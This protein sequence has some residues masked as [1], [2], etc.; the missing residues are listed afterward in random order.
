MG[1]HIIIVVNCQAM[2][3]APVAA[4]IPRVGESMNFLKTMLVIC[5]LVNSS[6]AKSRN[7]EV[8]LE[9]KY[10]QRDRSVANNWSPNVLELEN[11]KWIAVDCTAVRNDVTSQSPSMALE[12]S[13]VELN[14]ESLSIAGKKSRKAV[15]FYD[16]N[17]AI[18]MEKS[19]YKLILDQDSGR[20]ISVIQVNR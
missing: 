9:F 10:S 19:N 5:A 4:E 8:V 3:I 18:F 11:K 12:T 2:A 16:N 20:F 6:C 15:I 17:A 14:Y 1:G 7:D 13:R